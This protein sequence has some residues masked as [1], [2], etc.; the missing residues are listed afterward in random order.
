M[1][2]RCTNPNNEKYSLYGGRGIRVEFVGYVEFKAW[3][4]SSGYALGLSIDRIDSNGNYRPDN[5]R[6]ATPKQQSNNLRNNVTINAFGETKTVSQWVDDPRCSISYVALIQRCKKPGWTPEEAV[7]LPAQANGSKRAKDT[8]TEC[9]AGHDLAKTK[10]RNGRGDYRCSECTKIR[11]RG[12]D[13]SARK[14]GDAH[15]H[16]Q[17]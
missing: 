14:T 1:K 10:V 7:S 17:G 4:L 11:S 12:R 13:R 15:V 9:P 6:W 5:C 16:D 8:K 2:Q 3:A